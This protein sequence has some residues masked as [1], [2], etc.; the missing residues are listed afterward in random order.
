MRDLLVELFPLEWEVEKFYLWQVFHKTQDHFDIL[1]Y[2]PPANL[3][4]VRAFWK[5]V[6]SPEVKKKLV[7]LLHKEHYPFSDSLRQNGVAALVHLGC[8]KSELLRAFYSV[9]NGHTYYSQCE[10]ENTHHSLALDQS[11]LDFLQLYFK[12]KHK[13]NV[14]DILKCSVRT[15]ERRRLAILKKLGVEDLTEAWI[16]VKILKR[17]D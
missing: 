1:L 3:Q 14:A 11:D 4:E 7:L 12:C 13:E 5:D 17:N 16:S 2:E 15:V 10:P 6:Q 8:R 9:I